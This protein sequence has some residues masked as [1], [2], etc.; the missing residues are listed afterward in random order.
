MV[1][2]DEKQF[3][4]NAISMYLADFE[5]EGRNDKDIFDEPRVKVERWISVL[6]KY[7]GLVLNKCGAGKK[8]DEIQSYLSRLRIFDLRLGE[9]LTYA[10]VDPMELKLKNNEGD[11]EYYK[12]E[13]AVES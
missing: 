4:R 12:Y 7:K 3:L 10:M 9:I 8:Y 5:Q 13:D 11:L 2:N 6:E 1:R